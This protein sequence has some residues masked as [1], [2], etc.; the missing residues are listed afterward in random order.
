MYVDIFYSMQYFSSL[1]SSIF[2]TVCNTSLFYL[3]RVLFSMQCFF[4]LYSS[5]FSIICN[6]S[7]F[8]VHRYFVQVALLLYSSFDDISFSM[9]CFSNLHS[10]TFLM[11]LYSVFLCFPKGEHIATALS[12]RP[13]VRPSHFCPELIS[14]SFKGNLMKLDTLIEG[15][16]ANCRMQEP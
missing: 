10:S 4:I 12:V 14:K 3:C 8:D 11:L 13:T 15:H 6:V 2:S 5:I 9:Q 16:K 7:L 1:W